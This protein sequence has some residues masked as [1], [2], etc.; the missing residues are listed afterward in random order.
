MAFSIAMLF[1]I[2]DIMFVLNSPTKFP[3]IQIF[4][5]ATGSKGATTAMVCALILTL[6]FATFGTLA[7]ASRLA[8]AF[9]RD[10]GLPFSDYFAKV[11]KYYLIPTRAILLVTFTACLLGLVNIGSPIAFHALTSLALI[12]HYTSYL[13][14]ITLLVVR[15][16]GK[17]EVPWGP[18]TLG[19]WGLPI[20]LFA[21]AYSILLIGF[22][23]LP[24]YQPV[25]AGNMNYA[26]LIFGAAMMMSIVLWF[27][28]GKKTYWGP[29]REVIED[30]HIKQ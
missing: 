26:S 19:R 15:R 1:G 4:L 3:I 30:L 16:F 17:K 11:S 27:V 18:W 8:W 28:Y 10:K 20:N 29:V 12:G 7:C 23:L 13:L 22:M 21:M 9:A 24:P 6:V 14:P 5:T 2:G 25:N